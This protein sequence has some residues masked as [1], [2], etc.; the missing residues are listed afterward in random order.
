MAGGK[1]HEISMAE[2]SVVCSPAVA[3]TG[4]HVTQHAWCTALVEKVVILSLCFF[5][6]SQKFGSFNVHHL[7]ISLNK[8]PKKD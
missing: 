7:K 1:V 3:L 5:H 8:L 2:P 6:I 4:N